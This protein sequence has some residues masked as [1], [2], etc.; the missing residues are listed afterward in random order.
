M[1]KGTECPFFIHY[2]KM[3]TRFNV[4]KASQGFSGAEIELAVISAIYSGKA[5]ETQVGQ[6][7]LN[8]ELMKTGHCLW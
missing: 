2:F 6:A 1:I 3:D 7:L 4:F 5:T 8:R